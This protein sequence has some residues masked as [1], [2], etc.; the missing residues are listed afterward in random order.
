[1]HKEYRVRIA[2]QTRRW[3]SVAEACARELSRAKYTRTHAVI[4]DHTFRNIRHRTLT[5]IPRRHPQAD[6]E[7]RVSTRG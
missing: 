2:A 1:M 7:T 5:T 6:M 3:L 4:H